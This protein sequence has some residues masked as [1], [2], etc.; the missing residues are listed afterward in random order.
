MFHS[1][2]GTLK[3]PS[4]T[5]IYSSPPP[6]PQPQPQPQPQ[7]KEKLNYMYMYS[8]KDCVCMVHWYTHVLYMYRIVGCFRG[9]YIL[10]I[11]RNENFCEECTRKVPALGMW[12]WFSINFAKINSAN[13]CNFEIHEIY[14]PRK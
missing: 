12:V 1:V 14:T 3:F 7:P 6:L 13:C 5:P 10:R 2:G 4:L 9:V 11:W 8:H